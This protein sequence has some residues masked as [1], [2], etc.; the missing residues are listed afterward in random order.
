[1]NE[2]NATPAAIPIA[3]YRFPPDAL[4]GPKLPAETKYQPTTATKSSGRNFS[5]TVR[6][7]NQ[8]ICRTPARFTTAG[9]HRPS[10]AIPQFPMPDGWIPKR[11]ST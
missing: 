10:S 2:N 5:T 8:A 9:T 1:M 3:L 6:F 11:A 4:N 7:W